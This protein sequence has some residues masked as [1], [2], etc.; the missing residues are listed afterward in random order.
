MGLYLTF[1][2]FLALFEAFPIVPPEKEH[3]YGNHRKKDKNKGLVAVGLPK[4]ANFIQ[5]NQGHSQV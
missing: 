2:G 5:G 1:F 3:G 4:L